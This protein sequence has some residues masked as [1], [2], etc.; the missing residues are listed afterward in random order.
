ML[1]NVRRFRRSARVARTGARIYLGYKRTQR[2]TRR[3]SPED[4]AA[5]WEK[6][7]ERVAESLYRTAVDLKGIY[8]KYGQFVGTRADLFPAPYIRSLS[9]L[10]D[11]VPPRPVAEVRRTIER[12]LGRPVDELFSRFD[13]TPIATAS[14]AQVHRAALP[15]AREVAV[16]VQHP[17][18]AALVRLDLKN[19]RTLVGLVA[20]REPDFDYRAITEE[21]GTQVPLELDFEREAELTHRIAQNLRELPNLVFPDVIAGYVSKKVLTTGFIEGIPLNQPER[22]AAANP[23]RDQLIRTIAGAYGHQIMVDGVFQA[24]PH[25]GNLFLLPDGRAGILDFGL[26][27]ELP[28]S[29]RRGFARL[30]VAS[31]SRDGEG[32]RQAFQELGVKTKSDDSAE[33]FPLIGLFFDPRP[34]DG[35]QRGE[36][37]QRREMMRRNPIEAIPGD[38]VLLGR[39]VGLLRGVCAQLGTP[40]SPMQMLLPYAER[41]LAEP[42]TD[43]SAAG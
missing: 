38:L 1:D 14:L 36:L 25:P 24:D 30:V 9:R 2:R 22:I 15:D 43:V 8:V 21:I 34:I 7:H 6:Q 39:V 11:R 35:A 37:G 32:I 18:V 28:D 16:K 12:D 10:Q 26:T 23:D 41:A 5:A 31:A 4:S 13:A 33:I 42:A 3:M 40:L 17:E 27:K 19:M 20:R 29:S